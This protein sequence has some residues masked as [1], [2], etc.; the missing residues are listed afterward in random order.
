[1]ELV[2]LCTLAEVLGILESDLCEKYES[3]A[4]LEDLLE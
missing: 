3:K 1:M 2:I 4:F